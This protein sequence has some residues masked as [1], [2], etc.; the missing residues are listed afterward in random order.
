MDL[1]SRGVPGGF[2]ASSE[3]AEAAQAQ[4]VSLGFDPFRVFVEHPIQDR[5][6]QEIIR[7]ADRYFLDVLALISSSNG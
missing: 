2:V 4:A 1:D 5:S 3:F 7:L 6:D